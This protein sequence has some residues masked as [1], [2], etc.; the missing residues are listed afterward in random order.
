MTP[1]PEHEVAK[2]FIADFI[3]ILLEELS[4]DFWPLGS[5]TFKNKAMWQGIEPDDCFYIQNEA[6]VRQK[7]RL[8]L[9]TDPPPDLALEVDVTS[10]TN[11]EI[12]EG[13]KVPE[14][15][16]FN[17]GKLT[18]YLLQDNGKYV[19]STQSAIFPNLP[20]V[21]VIPVYLERAKIEGRNQTM[22]AFRAWVSSE[23]GFL[24]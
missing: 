2:I 19:E 4:I 18:I 9:A 13:L 1:L 12:Y 17:R 16:Q 8:D 21:D 14:L 23:T 6:A 10:P 11:R 24:A 3:K 7:D 5:T 22:R 20:V 15:W